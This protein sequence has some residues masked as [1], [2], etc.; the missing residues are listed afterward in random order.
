MPVIVE[1]LV[2]PEGDQQEG[3]NPLHDGQGNEVKARQH[4]GGHEGDRGGVAGR[5]GKERDPDGA[6][7]VLLEPQGQGEQP[8]HAGIQSVK[9]AEADHRQPRTQPVRKGNR[10]SR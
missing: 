7:A 2:D 5:D 10:K 8:A 6:S 9:G 4:A 1:Q 3:G